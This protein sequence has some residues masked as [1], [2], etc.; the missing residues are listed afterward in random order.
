[1][2]SVGHR[3]PC[4]IH[5]PQLHRAWL[6][7]AQLYG[8][9]SIPQPHYTKQVL[10]GF[11]EPNHGEQANMLPAKAAALWPQLEKAAKQWNLRIASP[12]A[13]PCGKQCTGDLKSPFDW[14]YVDH[15]ALEY[16][17]LYTEYTPFYTPPP[18]QGSVF[19]QLHRLPSRHSCNTLLWL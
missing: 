10:L 17:A 8:I 7:I 12:A 15:A 19:W 2:G 11:N 9:P 18:I 16:R 5:P 3:A 13:A 14:W 4:G 1:M 6:V